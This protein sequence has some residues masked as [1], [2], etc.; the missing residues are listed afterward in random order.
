M[1][2]FP[3]TVHCMHADDVARKDPQKW[4]VVQ[5]L[6]FQSVQ[7]CLIDIAHGNNCVTRDVSVYGTVQKSS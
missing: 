4:E 1:E 7:T 3:P 2:T 5:Q 6:K